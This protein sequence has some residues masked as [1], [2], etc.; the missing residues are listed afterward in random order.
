MHQQSFF[1]VIYFY[2]EVIMLPKSRI[3]A[4]LLTISVCFLSS[5]AAAK[6]GW[7]Q[8]KDRKGIK[9]YERP[10]KGTDL[11]EY[12]AA[13]TIDARIEVIG[14]ALRD[15]PHFNK[16]LADCDESFVLKSFN[17]NNMIIYLLLGPPII[18]DRDLILK[19]TVTYKYDDS[20]AIVKFECTKDLDVPPVEK[21]VRVTV[22]TGNF[23]MEYLGRDKTKFIY[24]LKV[25]PAGSI[26]KKIAY[27]VMKNYPYKTIHD[28][29]KHIK[30]NIK[31]YKDLAR[32]TEEEKQIDKRTRSGSHAKSILSGQLIRL[33][34][35]KK[36]LDAAVTSHKA[37]FEKIARNR[38]SYR[39][40]EEAAIKILIHYTE[41]VTK[42]KK[43]TKKLS[44][45]KKFIS[46]L[47]ELVQTA[48]AGTV[49][50]VDD[51]IAKYK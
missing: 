15:V 31:K 13:G 4:L 23:T 11:M 32:G 1:I 22:M 44:N 33:V 3:T 51:I 37:V 38:G 28:L 7:K 49:K 45:N 19:D 2:K 21:T 47:T 20:L 6:N 26:P 5:N 40:V 46:E 14:E 9:L 29:R 25:D 34:K 50:T 17:R 12:M 18:Q 36:D 24:S 43:L 30:K 48:N 10:V 39:I 35:N 42:D 16:W 41:I 27:G 8:T